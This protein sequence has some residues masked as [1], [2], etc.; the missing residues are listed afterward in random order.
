MPSNQKLIIGLGTGRCGTLTLA[1]VLDAQFRTNITHEAYWRL[2]WKPINIYLEITLQHIYRH[3]A[4][5]IGDV[6]FYYLNYVETI[7]SWI[8]KTKFVCLQR[9]R[10]G[11]I[12]SQM[13][14]GT[15]L[16]SNHFTARDSKHFNH[17]R[18][19]LKNN[20]ESR[21]YRDSFPKYD[22]PR[23]EAARMYW[24]E[25]FTIAESF[26]K[27]YPDNF[28]IFDMDAA[29]NTIDGQREMLKFSGVNSEYILPKLRV[30]K[31]F[32]G[33]PDQFKKEK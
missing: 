20:E 19:D 7:L 25:F 4:D 26:Q 23:K 3:T 29:L 24:D 31:K 6:S 11:V 2:P 15:S 16:G 28:K 32:T 14:C 5:F 13:R 22:A 9:P 17:E 8:P 30:F 21:I 12:E 27:K 1:A 10:E 18:C 33:D